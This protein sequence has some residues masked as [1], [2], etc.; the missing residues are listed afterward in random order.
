MIQLVLKL[1]RYITNLEGQPM[2]KQIS[3]PS[4]S[5][6]LACSLGAYISVMC[7]K[8]LYHSVLHIEIK[9]NSS[10]RENHGGKQRHQDGGT[11]EQKSTGTDGVH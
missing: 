2:A 3:I 7:S 10:Q 6:I 8:L 11:H 9:H 5:K 1:G 4:A